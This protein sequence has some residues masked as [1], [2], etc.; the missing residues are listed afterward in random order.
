MICRVCPN[1][2]PKER[3]EASP[4]TVTC[5]SPCSAEYKRQLWN[6]GRKRRYRSDKSTSRMNEMRGLTV[7]QP[8][9]SHLADGR[10]H[11][12]TRSYDT[13]FRGLVAIH[14]GK[15]SEFVERGYNG[16][17]GAIVAV[18]RLANSTETEDTIRRFGITD[19]EMALGD[20]IPGRYAWR[21]AWVMRLDEPIRV[22]GFQM[23]WKLPIEVEDRLRAMWTE[24][25]EH[26]G[27]EIEWQNL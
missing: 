2:V 10:K 11:Y 3:L 26:K 1:P 19:E 24:H 9:A 21:M 7:R 16:P 14:A 23:F 18:A 20:W 22:R 13:Q 12:E 15:S 6:A 8:W 17:L 4:R 27:R 5:S 25:W